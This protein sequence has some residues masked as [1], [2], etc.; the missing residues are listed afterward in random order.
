MFL[1]NHIK[2]PLHLDNIVTGYITQLSSPIHFVRMGACLRLG[3]LPKLLLVGKLSFI[4]DK[5]MHCVVTIKDC[6]PKFVEA[7]RDAV[8]A[9]SKLVFTC[10]LLFRKVSKENI[11][12]S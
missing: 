12:A 3:A 10:R 6:D 8:K 11:V 2:C 7:R 5:L 1:H 9:I 4:L